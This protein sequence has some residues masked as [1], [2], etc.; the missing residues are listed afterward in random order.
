MI[1]FNHILFGVLL[2]G[3]A[4]CSRAPRESVSWGD[5]TRELYAPESIADLS[6]PSSKLYSSYDR[7]GGNEDHTQGFTKQGERL[8]LVTLKGPGVLTRFWFTGMQAETRIGFY[9]DGEKTP[10]LEATSGELRSGKGGFPEKWIDYDQNCFTLYGTLPYA[11]NLSIRVTDDGYSSGQGGKLYYQCNATRLDRRV[12]SATFPVPTSVIEAATLQE[13][14]REKAPASRSGAFTV[15]P[16]STSN[17]LEW[18]G[19]GT[20]RRLTVDI[21]GW[22]AMSYRRQQALLRAVWVHVEWDDSSHLS[23]RV[24]LGDLFGMMWEPYPVQHPFVRAPGEEFMFRL[25]MPFRS[26]V[27]IAFS[28]K[29][30]VPVQGNIHVHLDAD[31]PPETDGYFHAGWNRSPPESRGW[32]HRA[33]SAEGRGRLAGCLLGVASYGQNFSMLESDET[34]TIDGVS[35]WQGTGL[36]D[37]FNGGWYYRKPFERALYGLQLKR[38]FRTVQYRYHLPDAICF[39]ESIS[40]SF[41]RG[42]ANQAPAGYDSLVFYYLEEPRPAFG[43]APEKAEPFRDEY[44]PNS[45]MTRLW[46]YEREGAFRQASSLLSYAMDSWPYSEA[47]QDVFKVRSLIYQAFQK[48]YGDVQDGLQAYAG[49]ESP[50]GEAAER[51]IAHFEQGEPLLFL[52]ANK[53]ATVWLNQRPMG[54]VQGPRD[55]FVQAVSGASTSLQLLVQSQAMAWPDWVQAGILFPDSWEVASSEWLWTDAPGA[56]PTSAQAAVHPVSKV[57]GPPEMEVVPFVVP[58]A[59]PR[60]QSGEDAIRAQGKNVQR[61]NDLVFY[62][63]FQVLSRPTSY[64]PPPE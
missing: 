5:L 62:R 12:P 46:D 25:P 34:I 63:T 48:G 38:P 8:E 16:T 9:F 19:A 21:Q 52:Y 55:L 50:A 51:W 31:K 41:E 59:Y 14:P 44:E 57:K 28:N 24:P 4:G 30:D 35:S 1:R 27:R 43:I 32:P 2:L 20:I 23:V 45:L 42:V 49:T 29:G 10:R 54:S 6:A 37:Y 26:G 64:A 15:Q 11:K 60:L 58:D 39:E 3:M 22:G 56:K 36:E 33:L 13:V 17:V 61:P 53:P 40:L 7:S 18:A 47:V